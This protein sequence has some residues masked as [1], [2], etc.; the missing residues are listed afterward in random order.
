MVSVVK[1]GPWSIMVRVGMIFGSTI[2]PTVCV[3][4]LYMR[5]ASRHRAKK[6]GLAAGAKSPNQ[7]DGFIGPT[8]VVPLLQDAFK[9]AFGTKL[10]GT[11]CDAC[12]AS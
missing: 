5:G 9:A 2:H 12:P 4:R 6:K 1:S 10:K 8:E 3:R 11:G 7:V